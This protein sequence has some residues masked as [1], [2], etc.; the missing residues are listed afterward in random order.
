[1]GTIP[2]ASSGGNW[3]IFSRVPLGSAENINMLIKGPWLFQGESL[4][5][6]ILYFNTCG[7]WLSLGDEDLV[8]GGWN[9]LAVTNCLV[10]MGARQCEPCNLL[11]GGWVGAKVLCTSRVPFPSVLAHRTTWGE[12]LN[13][14]VQSNLERKGIGYNFNSRRNSMVMEIPDQQSG[15]SKRSGTN[16]YRAHSSCLLLCS[17]LSHTLAKAAQTCCFP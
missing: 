1:M 7:L 5:G 13:P 10:A 12:S 4:V 6:S 17:A 3:L 14:V 11:V 15:R 16:I 9:N 2:L 8:P